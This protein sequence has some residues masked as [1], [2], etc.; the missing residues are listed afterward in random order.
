MLLDEIRDR[1]AAGV[2]LAD[3][4]AEVIGAWLERGV[5]L[6]RPVAVTSRC[7]WPGSPRAIRR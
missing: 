4:A 1:A 3:A 2:P 6:P 5:R 7:R